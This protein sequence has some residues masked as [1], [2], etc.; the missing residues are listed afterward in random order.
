[1][2]DTE[3]KII[4]NNKELNTATGEIQLHR[5]SLSFLATLKSYDEEVNELLELNLK[6]KEEKQKEFDK[7]YK[8]IKSVHALVK[9]GLNASGLLLVNYKTV[10]SLPKE[11]KFPEFLIGGGKTW[12][13]LILGTDNATAKLPNGCYVS[14]LGTPEILE[15]VW[16]DYEYNEIKEPIAFGSQVLLHI[17]TKDLYGQELKINLTDKDIFTPNDL[18]YTYRREVNI[19]KIHPKDEGRTGID[20]RVNK[21]GKSVQHIQKIT[22][23]VVVD[24]SWMFHAGKSLKVFPAILSDKTGKY[25]SGFKRN[26]L[27][28]KEGG[29]GYVNPDSK[30]NVAVMVG[31]VETNI[32]AFDPCRYTK[33]DLKYKDLNSVLF[34]VKDQINTANDVIEIGVLSNSAENAE[35]VTITVSN[36]NTEVCDN[37]PELHTNKVIDISA[38]EK[39]IVEPKP[40]YKE[41][42][43]TTLEFIPKY[44]YKYISGKKKDFLPFFLEYFPAFNEKPALIN[45][46]V[47]TCAYQKK[48]NL[49]IYPDAAFAMHLQIGNPIDYTDQS[50]IYY[51]NIDLQSKSKLVRG[52]ENEM[53]WVRQKSKE[54]EIITK[55]L[56]NSILNGIV[57]EIVYDY[58]ENS[59]KDLAAGF[60]GYHTFTAPNEATLINYSKQYEW[61]PKT[62]IIGGVIL[63]AAVDGLI[64]Y[65][66]RGK[67]AAV[68]SASL[69]SKATQAYKIYRK[70]N[71]YKK[72]A[73]KLMTGQ[74]IDPAKPNNTITEFIWP[75]IAATRAI[76]YVSQENGN[77]AV[78]LI[79]RLDAAP[80]FALNHKVTGSLGSI[81]AGFVGITTIFDTAE[82][83]V[84]V[85]GMLRDLKDAKKDIENAPASSSS[86]KK[87]TTV[88]ATD[89]IKEESKGFTP[90]DYLRFKDMQVF[91]DALERKIHAKIDKKFN[92]LFGTAAKVELDFIGYYSAHYEFRV[93]VLENKMYLDI[94]ED[95]KKPYSFSNDKQLTFGRD[96]GVALVLKFSANSQAEQKWSKLNDYTPEFLGVSFSDTKVD[97]NVQGE[98][99]GSLNFE[100]TFKWAVKNKQPTVRDTIIFTGIAG[101]LYMNLELEINN[102]NDWETIVDEEIG[103]TNADKPEE[104]KPINVELI[105][106]FTINFDE[107]PI[108]EQSFWEYLMR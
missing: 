5:D 4:H 42:G 3:I 60:H 8:H 107:Q 30:G 17:Y 32:E 88:S 75:Q 41:A 23:P 104:K 11:I 35:T 47:T 101:S 24:L 55:Y 106:G 72:T 76:G 105:P 89:V 39:I 56:P 33:I 9:N 10:S 71:R 66:T 1:M 18:L 25:F 98:V 49:R 87:N 22:I 12:L 92:E 52:L 21:E 93:N 91:L 81:V 19:E 62:M 67:S 43:T 40:I 86:D 48:L 77:V 45:L 82:Q 84:G 54:A 80:L 94:F 28:V 74:F 64:L 61:I 31:K 13:E 70:Y 29:K 97:T 20:G 96:Y 50:K 57:Q 34:S 37:K 36:V 102:D 53:K 6:N 51:R 95:Q 83:A 59:A 68:Q 99:K 90:A 108:F 73:T 16:T 2:N 65:L 26:Y 15:T 100:R 27:T 63:S 103:T 14:A 44:P 46:P 38:L 85:V 58:I 7:K 78:E 79:E 69:L